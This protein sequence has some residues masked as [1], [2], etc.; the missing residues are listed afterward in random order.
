MADTLAVKGPYT[1]GSW[2]VVQRGP[3]G[4]LHGRGFFRS[5]AQAEDHLQKLRAARSALP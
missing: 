2:G 1:D 4:Q 5:R 3:D